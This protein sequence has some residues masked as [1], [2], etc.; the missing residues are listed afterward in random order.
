MFS[1]SQKSALQYVFVVLVNYKYEKK[2]N[3]EI[4]LHILKGK[5]NQQIKATKQKKPRKLFKVQVITI[6]FA[7]TFK[8]LITEE[9][10]FTLDHLF[11]T[12]VVFLEAE[13]VAMVLA[14]CDSWSQQEAFRPLPA[15]GWLQSSQSSPCIQMSFPTPEEVIIL[16]FL[17]NMSK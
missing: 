9:D 1:Q 15:L 10:L 6:F 4:L 16:I 11:L 14:H 2:F 8:I 17:Y 13:F 5:Q 3:I 12:D 7:L